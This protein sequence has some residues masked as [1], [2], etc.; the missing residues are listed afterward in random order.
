MGFFLCV[1]SVNCIY[2]HNLM[3]EWSQTRWHALARLHFLGKIPTYA[4]PDLLGGTD[5]IIEHMAC[6]L[7]KLGMLKP[8]RAN[9][10]RISALGE[11]VEPQGVKKG[12]M[13]QLIMRRLKG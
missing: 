4:R 2:G 5:E 11:E 10:L 12:R 7:E 9:D 1:Q 6:S 3:E 13:N 8:P